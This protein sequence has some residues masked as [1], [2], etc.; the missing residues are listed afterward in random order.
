MDG[1]FVGRLNVVLDERITSY[2]EDLPGTSEDFPIDTL[3]QC[4]DSLHGVDLP[5]EG[6]VDNVS[7]DLRGAPDMGAVDGAPLGDLCVVDDTTHVV[8]TMGVTDILLDP[9]DF[10]FVTGPGSLTDVSP[11][12]SHPMV[13]RRKNGSES[14]RFILLSVLV[15]MLSQIQLRKHFI[16]LNGRKLLR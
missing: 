7:N 4:V 10:V 11:V 1:F 15:V 12:C 8:A 16:V 5:L 3:F 13:S 6:L 14:L 9:T 2:L